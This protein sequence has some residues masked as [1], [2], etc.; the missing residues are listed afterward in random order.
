MPVVTLGKGIY[1][2]TPLAELRFRADS[3]IFWQDSAARLYYY[4]ILRQR[5]TM[6]VQE[7]SASCSQTRCSRRPFPRFLHDLGADG[8]E[9]SEDIGV[10][11]RA[12]RVPDET[13]DSAG[14]EPR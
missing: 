2:E 14:K 8:V 11:L 4:L 10:A 12:E 1:G 5:N 3:L 13:C 7:F 9:L 6:M